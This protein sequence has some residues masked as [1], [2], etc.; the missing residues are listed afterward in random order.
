MKANQVVVRTFDAALIACLVLGGT[1][2]QTF[3]FWMISIM[4]ALTLL[5]VFGM[6]AE[7]AEK[8][9]G[10]SITKKVIGISWGCMYVAALIYAEFPI[11]AA[12]YTMVVMIIRVSA[13]AKL[14]E[15]A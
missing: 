4:V 14:K 5:G 9:Q 3:A 8:I 11:L 10:R 7:L 12:L 1:D 15:A 6:N 13:E 2:V